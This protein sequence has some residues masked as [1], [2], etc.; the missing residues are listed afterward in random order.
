LNAKIEILIGLLDAFGN[1]FSGAH[2]LSAMAE[3]ASNLF[4]DEVVFT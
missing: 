3:T 1:S 4:R 2:A